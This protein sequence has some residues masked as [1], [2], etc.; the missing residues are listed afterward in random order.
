[1]QLAQKPFMKK[2]AST[3]DFGTLDWI[4]KNNDVRISAYYG[5]KADWEKLPTKWEDFEIK[6]FN[7]D[8]AAADEFKLDHGYDE[9]KPETEL[10]IEDMKPGC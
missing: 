5:T 2:I 6:Q 1:M 4:E 9:S 8:S 7:K 10:D 3:P